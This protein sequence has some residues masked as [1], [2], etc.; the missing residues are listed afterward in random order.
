MD[1]TE[2][3]KVLAESLRNVRDQR[4]RY[5]EALEQVKNNEQQLIG[6]LAILEELERAEP[7]ASTPTA[8][9]VEPKKNDAGG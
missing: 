4:Q 8:E 5:S 6:A 1:L 7:P 2:R 3:K 9:L